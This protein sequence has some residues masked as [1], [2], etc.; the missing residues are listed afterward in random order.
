MK[1]RP[2][3]SARR[4]RWSRHGAHPC[5]QILH[6]QAP[7]FQS[8]Q[9][10]R[11]GISNPESINLN[12]RR[13][14]GGESK[15]IDVRSPVMEQKPTSSSMIFDLHPRPTVWTRPYDVTQ[16]PDLCRRPVR[17]RLSDPR[18]TPGTDPFVPVER[19]HRGYYTRALLS[20]AHRGCH[21][22]LPREHIR[23]FHFDIQHGIEMRS[24]RQGLLANLR[25]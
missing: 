11:L 4:R 18:Y 1:R 13:Q 12:A 22:R 24:G 21:W 8:I 10:I 14:G 15:G 9:S 16:P 17:P 6:R 7:T 2:R 3:S 23:A 19:G 5:C 20:C 25:L